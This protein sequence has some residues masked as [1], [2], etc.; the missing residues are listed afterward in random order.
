MIAGDAKRYW[1]N[2]EG[3]ALIGVYV[4]PGQYPVKGPERIERELRAILDGGVRCLQVCSL[5]D[6]LNDPGTREVFRKFAPQK[7]AN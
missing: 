5:N 1:P 2:A 6:V 7:P 3:G 4:R